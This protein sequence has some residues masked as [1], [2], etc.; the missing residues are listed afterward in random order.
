MFHSIPVKDYKCYTAWFHQSQ[1][2]LKWSCIWIEPDEKETSDSQVNKFHFSLVLLY[3][4]KYRTTIVIDHNKNNNF[5][6][7]ISLIS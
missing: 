6:D 3:P 5:C 4:I 2:T 7:F 1:W